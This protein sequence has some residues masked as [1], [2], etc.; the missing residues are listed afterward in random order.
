MKVQFKKNYLPKSS[1][2]YSAAHW[3]GL[4]DLVE[5]ENHSLNGVDPN[6]L[7]AVN[8]AAKHGHLS[9][10]KWLCEKNQFSLAI[11]DISPYKDFLHYMLRLGHLEIIKWLVEENK[12]SLDEIDTERVV[13]SAIRNKHFSLLKWLVEEKHYAIRN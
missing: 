10:V 8:L 6:N 1:K 5:K 13:L 2:Q 4:I 9:I 12:F 11:D 3:K 7:S